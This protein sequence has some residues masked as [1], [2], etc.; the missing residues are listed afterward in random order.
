MAAIKYT[1]VLNSFVSTEGSN[2]I[3]T[4]YIYYSV[5]VVFDNGQRK[6]V[7][8][9]LHEINYLLAYVRTPQDY[10]AELT[11]TVKGMRKEISELVDQK[12]GYVVD[13]LYP[14]PEIRD[15]NELEA[16]DRLREAG[17]TP[18]LLIDYPEG[19][20]KNGFVSAYSRNGANFR[21]VDVTV[22]HEMPKVVGLQQ[23]EAEALLR[24]A[25]FLVEVN[26]KMVTDQE[27]GKVLSCLRKGSESMQVT[28]DVASVIPETRGM[29]KADAIE[30][31][32]RAGYRVQVEERIDRA[33]PGT[34]CFWK[35]IGDHQIQLVCSMAEKIVCKAVNVSCPDMQESTGDEYSASAEFSHRTNQLLIRVNAQLGIKSKRQIVSVS[36]K[37][38]GPRQPVPRLNIYQLDAGI[39]GM[40]I[41]MTYNQKP[42]ALPAGLTILLDTQYGIMKKKETV[43]M[44][45]TMEW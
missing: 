38:A 3:M 6:V 8:G 2:G 35:E 34:V 1:Q 28:M 36:C 9:K 41:T 14:I 23:E 25:G 24:E 17:L 39:N 44:Q 4:N 45:F 22:F 7:E 16:L 27:N 19:T 15:L 31:L 20:P 10:L 11:E 33:D 5:L 26:A 30:T 13:T 29:Q 21:T 18:K 42:D 40:N 37:E 12:I 43:P 32:Q